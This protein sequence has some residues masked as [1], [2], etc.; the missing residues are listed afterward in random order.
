MAE[1]RHGVEQATATGA[2]SAAKPAPADHAPADH[3]VAGAQAPESPPGKSAHVRRRMWIIA[4]I[5]AGGVLFAIFGVPWLIQL[6]NTVSTDDAYVNGH[7]TYVAARVPGQ[8]MQVL[9]D[10]NYRV[11]KGDLLV[12]LDK[13]PY[14]VIVDQKQAALSVAESNLVVAKDE[15]RAQIGQA[16]AARF[17]LEHAI[18]DV[19]NQIAVLRANVATVQ[20]YRAKLALA[21]SDYRRALELEKTPGAIAQQDVDTREEALRTAEA[22]LQQGIQ[23]VYQVRASLGLPIEPAKGKDLTDVPPDLDQTFSSVRSALYQLLQIVAPLGII[24]SSYN[25]TPKQVIAEF[26]ARDPTGNLD[27]I[28]A[29]IIKD[30]P[31]IKFAQS[32]VMVAQSDLEQAKLNL[33]Y[34]DILAEIDGVITRRQVNPGNN[35]VAGQSLMALRSLTEIWVDANFKETQ[36]SHIRIGQPADLDVDM[37]GSHHV[38]KGR[39]SGFTMGTGSTLAILPPENATGNFVKVVQRLPI[40]IDLIDYDPDKIPLFVGLSV[41]P[42]VYIYKQPTGPGAGQFLQP[43]TQLPILPLEQKLTPPQPMKTQ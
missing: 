1:S 40:R 32:Q 24:P 18:E 41:E 5:I 31:A 11:R 2:P 20:T 4:A 19:N 6:I 29:K 23:Q 27:K 10:D 14:Q 26:Y 9:V 15:V 34:C 22:Q 42:H 36:I 28:Y 39:V 33:S 25:L 38:F 13:Q 3:A 35:V 16:R 17:K 21:Q 43:E 7:V 8:V 37:Y 30:A 12:Q